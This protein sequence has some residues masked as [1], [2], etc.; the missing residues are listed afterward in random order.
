MDKIETIQS[1]KKNLEKYQDCDGSV[2]WTFIESKF[3]SELL[4][5]KKFYFLRELIDDLRICDNA[6]CTIFP[7]LHELKQKLKTLKIWGYNSFQEARQSIENELDFKKWEKDY[8]E[9]DNF[10]EHAFSQIFALKTSR[11]AQDLKHK[12][13]HQEY[14]DTLTIINENNYPMPLQIEG[15]VSAKMDEITSTA[16]GLDDKLSDKRK[17]FQKFIKEQK[18]VKKLKKAENII[19]IDKTGTK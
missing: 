8:R 6:T 4:F 3:D 9:F 5:D 17:V 19:T 7:K 15:A 11:D 18:E 16:I 12:Q 13:Y 1:D 14:L 2:D 10:A